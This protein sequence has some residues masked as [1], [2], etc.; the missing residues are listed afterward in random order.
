MAFLN[1][2]KKSVKVDA[3]N[4][5][6]KYI[7]CKLRKADVMRGSFS[8]LLNIVIFFLIFVCLVI[9]KNCFLRIYLQFPLRTS[10]AV[11]FIP[12]ILLP[13]T[14]DVMLLICSRVTRLPACW[15][16]GN[17]R[18]SD[19]QSLSLDPPLRIGKHKLS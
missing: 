13:S 11:I 9:K 17:D 5:I 12:Y 7:T 6:C 18:T 1:I 10:G 15:Q 3:L 14:Y 16:T 19:T 2:S 4:G 8:M